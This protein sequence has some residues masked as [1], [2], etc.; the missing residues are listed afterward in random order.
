MCIRDRL[1]EQLVEMNLFN[2]KLLYANKLMQNRD[3]TAKQ[4]RAIVEALDNAKTLR[5]AKLLYK[6][7]T[8]S[9]NKR[10]SKKNLAEGRSTRSLGSASKSAQSAQPAKSAGSMDRWA[11]LAGINQDK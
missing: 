1:K 11:I 4:Q 7:L 9:L 3:L 5:E 6:S 8:S 2:A 10:S